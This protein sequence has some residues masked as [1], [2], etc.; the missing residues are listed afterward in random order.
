M[1]VHYTSDS[2][3]WSVTGL[4]MTTTCTN[5]NFDTYDLTSTY[6]TPTLDSYRYMD[7]NAK[8]IFT[9]K[10]YYTEGAMTSSILG[11]IKVCS[12]PYVPSDVAYIINP[13]DMHSSTGDWDITFDTTERYLY[14]P[15]EKD[16]KKIQIKNNL[17]IQVK[18]RAVELPKNM[19]GNERAAMET[20][21]EM[22]S[23]AEF[24]KYLRYGFVLVKSRSGKTYQVFRNKWHTKV[25]KGGKLIE[26]ICV[27]IKDKNIPPTDNVIAFKTLIEADEEDFKSLGNVYKMAKAA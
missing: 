23:E 20:L 7:S 16:L 18:S 3:D 12:S 26:E 1:A 6:I 21:R 19:M 17:V 24:R 2:G 11:N 22:I 25:W 8:I 4:N 14:R 9:S 27:R 10:N 15:S 5:R 13:A